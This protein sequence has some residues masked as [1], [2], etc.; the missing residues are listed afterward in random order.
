M[1]QKKT[2]RWKGIVLSMFDDLIC[3]EKV[4]K[5]SVLMYGI[6]FI[7]WGAAG[8]VCYWADNTNFRI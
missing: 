1:V 5:L 8:V 3:S 2:I 6:F 4:Y 7:I